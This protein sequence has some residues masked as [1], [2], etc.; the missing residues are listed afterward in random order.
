MRNLKLTERDDYVLTRESR[1]REIP[2]SNTVAGHLVEVFSGFLNLKIDKTAK[3]LVI[4]K[5]KCWVGP[6]MPLLIQFTVS[7]DL[8]PLLSKW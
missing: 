6:H 3:E 5:G 1:I 4:F 8:K 2:G 7:Q